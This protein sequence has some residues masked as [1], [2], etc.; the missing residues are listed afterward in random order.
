M[1]VTDPAP[2]EGPKGAWVKV[3]G[4]SGDEAALH[5]LPAGDAVYVLGTS[6]GDLDGD[7]ASGGPFVLALDAEPPAAIR[8][9]RDLIGI[10]RSQVDG[11][12]GVIR[13]DPMLALARAHRRL[14]PRR[15]DGFGCRPTFPRDSFAPGRI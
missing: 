1:T 14:R 5:V 15:A 8:G 3:L 6:T 10:R 4:T 12:F 7:G 2:T 11:D 13:L 9:K